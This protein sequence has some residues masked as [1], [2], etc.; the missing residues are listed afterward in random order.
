MELLRKPVS[1][2]WAALMLATIASTWLLSN[3]SVTPEVA[4]VA[5]MLIRPQGAV[6][7][8]ALHGGTSGATGAQFVCDSWLLA[9]T[10]LILTVYLL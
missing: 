7:D 9:V 10:A 4:T 5:I 3:N 6:R 2:A 8:Q 1:I